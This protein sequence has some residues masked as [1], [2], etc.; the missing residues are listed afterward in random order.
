[1]GE[2]TWEIEI[3]TADGLALHLKKGGISTGG[4]RQ[5]SDMEAPLDEYEEIYAKF[6]R[7]LKAKR[8]DTDAGRFN[9]C[10]TAS[11]REGRRWWRRLFSICPAECLRITFEQDIQHHFRPV[12]EISG[13]L[14]MFCIFIGN[15]I[16]AFRPDLINPRIGVGH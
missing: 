9:W 6:A 10:A 16:K 13:H 1:M 14:K 11:C 15:A 8:S 2:Q 7:L 12:E 5:D 4:Q 3:A